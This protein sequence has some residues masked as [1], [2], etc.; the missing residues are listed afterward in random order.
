MAL[1]AGQNDCK[2]VILDFDSLARFKLNR[3]T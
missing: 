3:I 1:I 2:K